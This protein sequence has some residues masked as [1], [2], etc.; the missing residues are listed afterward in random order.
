MDRRLG[1]MITMIHDTTMVNTG[2]KD[3]K[4]NLE[5]KNDTLLSSTINSRRA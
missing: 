2:R 4:R 5:I 1:G 3:A